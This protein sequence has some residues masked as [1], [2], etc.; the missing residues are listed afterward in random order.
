MHS[1][2]GA[3][4]IAGTD[5]TALCIL[6][7]RRQLRPVPSSLAIASLQMAGRS[8]KRGRYC[9]RSLVVPDYQLYLL[10]FLPNVSQR[11]ALQKTG[12]VFSP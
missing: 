8:R 2:L 11:L 1:V 12:F 3:G 6:C 9:C 10:L 4:T 5:R 7:L